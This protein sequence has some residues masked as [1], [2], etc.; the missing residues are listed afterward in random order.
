MK[1]RKKAKKYL[2]KIVEFYKAVGV[3]LDTH[4]HLVQG[5]RFII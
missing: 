1:L 2:R 4:G 3:P 5:S